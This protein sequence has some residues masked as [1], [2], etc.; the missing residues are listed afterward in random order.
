MTPY[1]QVNQRSYHRPVLP[2]GTPVY[3]RRS[4]ALLRPK[5]D[6]RWIPGLWLC[7]HAAGDEHIVITELGMITSR[8]CKPM[9]MD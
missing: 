8:T 9:P 6:A 4:D 7:R 3:V 5:L 1:E 2:L